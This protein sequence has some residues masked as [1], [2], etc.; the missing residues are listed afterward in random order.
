MLSIIVPA[1]NESESLPK[2]FDE[3]SQVAAANSLD[4]EVI[5]IDD[6]SKD[7]SWQVI[8]RLAQQDERVS[9][10]RF[11]RNFGKAAALTAG[12]RAAR[13]STIMMMDADLQDDPVEIPRFLARLEE[14]ADVVNGWKENRLDPWHKVYPSKVFN[15][16]AGKMTGLRLHDHNCGFKLFRA[17]VAAE[18]RIYGELH[19]FIP[20]LAHARG[21]DVAEIPVHHRKREF[22]YSKYGVKRFVRG[23]LDLVTV[24]FLTGYGQRP[25]HMLGAFG[26]FS[27]FLGLLGVAYLGVVWMMM[28]AWERCRVGSAPDDDERLQH[29]LARADRD[30]TVVGVFDRRHPL[31]SAGEVAGV[32]GGIDRLQYRARQRHL[33]RQNA[34]DIRADHHRNSA[35]TRAIGS[36]TERVIRPDQPANCSPTTD[37]GTVDLVTRMSD[38]S[39]RPGRPNS[40]REVRL[41]SVD[42]TSDDAS[43]NASTTA[44]MHHDSHSGLAVSQAICPCWAINPPTEISSVGEFACVKF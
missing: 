5:F 15:W 38:S 4:V 35:G 42:T 40:A 3:I 27:F 16:L 6:G 28:V 9:G 8:D 31:G 33:Q 25:Q 30:A 2:L 18:I 24:K 17:E 7:D 36:G 20:V 43:N 14:G 11:R 39:R 44:D 26:L 10:I 41:C 1:L 19:R 37:L 29:T 34:D 23:L 32:A 12:M 21:F 13:G 22:G